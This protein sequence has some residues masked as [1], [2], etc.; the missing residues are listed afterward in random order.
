MSA[1]GRMLL[2]VRSALGRHKE[3]GHERQWIGKTAKF[4][5]VS[6]V[7]TVCLLNAVVAFVLMRTMGVDWGLLR[8]ELLRFRAAAK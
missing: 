3:A 1:D 6:N 4:T 2:I 5:S 8:E 7:A